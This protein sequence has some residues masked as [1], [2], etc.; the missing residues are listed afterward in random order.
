MQC[1]RQPL[2]SLGWLRKQCTLLIAG[3]IPTLDSSKTIP[4]LGGPSFDVCLFQPYHYHL[5]IITIL[6]FIQRNF[7]FILTYYYYV[8]C[9]PIGIVVFFGLMQ[10]ICER[11]PCSGLDDKVFRSNQF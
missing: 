8:F 1:P 6:E 11:L 7:I 5:V 3:A 4:T 10:E 2:F 9:S